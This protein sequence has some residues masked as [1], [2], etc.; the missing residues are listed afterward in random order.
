MPLSIA[1]DSVVSLSCILVV[2]LVVVLVVANSWP[3]R[4]QECC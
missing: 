3:I 2:V 1:A 4:N